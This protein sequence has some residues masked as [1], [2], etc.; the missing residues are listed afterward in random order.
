[1]NAA[2]IQA[3]MG[4]SRLSGKVMM[5]VDNN[6]SVLSYVVNQ[7]KHCNLLDKIII[8]ITNLS[9]DEKIVEFA[10]KLEIPYFRGNPTDVL[11]RYYQCAKKFSISTIIRITSDDPLI[12]PTIVDQIIEK[13]NSS[14]F[15]YITN[16]RPRTYP[17]G[18][19]AEIFSFSTLE[20]AWQNAKKPS[21]REHVT[22]YL[23]NNP[24][25]FKIFNIEYSKNIS[26]LRWTVDMEQDLQFVKAVVSKI[27]KRPIL[28]KDI[29]SLLEKEPD[30]VNINKDYIMDEGYL[31]SIKEDNPE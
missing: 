10:N 23:F 22:P 16:C 17:Q 29:I 3:R 31:K 21:E 25:K 7:L 12:D 8:A 6:K 19:E 5:K 27:P 11:D 28:M 30:L 1:M 24:K 18:T 2:I 9:E 20:T 13:F 15:D 14:S 26:H 4:S